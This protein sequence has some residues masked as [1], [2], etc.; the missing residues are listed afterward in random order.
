[1][2]SLYNPTRAFCHDLYSL[3]DP[4][5]VALMV[6]FSWF[7]MKV[8]LE[9]VASGLFIRNFFKAASW[10][11]V[12]LKVL[13]TEKWNE[14]SRVFWFR[15]ICSHLR[16]SWPLDSIIKPGQDRLHFLLLFYYLPDRKRG[17]LGKV[18]ITGAEL[19][20]SRLFVS[21]CGLKSMTQRFNYI[22][23]KLI[24]LGVVIIFL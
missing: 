20:C 7:L 12:L 19:L 1:M 16:W 13:Y 4:E 24:K 21:I 17:C 23:R 5:D 6:S 14:L 8:L 22:V 15:A 18:L 10:P 11:Y 9:S 2:F 3:C